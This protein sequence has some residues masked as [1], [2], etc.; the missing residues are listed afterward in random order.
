MLNR[1]TCLAAGTTLIAALSHNR[2]EG[3]P[4][5]NGVPIAASLLMLQA[6]PIV[7]EAFPGLSMSAIFAH[8][9]PD[10]KYKEDTFLGYATKVTIEAPVYER[11]EQEEQKQITGNGLAM[12]KVATVRLHGKCEWNCAKAFLTTIEMYKLSGELVWKQ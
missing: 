9:H 1:W 12:N 3:G 2:I 10:F 4:T 6:T 5:F 11:F 8:P 7:E